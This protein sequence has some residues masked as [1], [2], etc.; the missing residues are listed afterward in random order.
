MTANATAQLVTRQSAMRRGP[1]PLD[2]LLFFVTIPVSVALMFSLVG[3]RLTNGMPW[4]DSFG[5]LIIHMA[6]TWGCVSLSCYAVRRVCRSWRPPV[7]AICII[8]YLAAV[9]PT[10]YVYQLTGDFFASIYPVF[11]LN[12]QDHAI[13]SWGLDYLLHFIRYAIPAL[14][15][16][17]VGTFGYRYLTGVNWFGYPPLEAKDA[18]PL[19][20]A[21]TPLASRIVND[22][23]PADAVIIAIKAEQHYIHIYSD[24]GTALVRYRF[25]DLDKALSGTNGS[26]VHRSWW[27][28]YDEVESS[29]PC[30]RTI[31]LLMKGDLKVPVSLSN[32]SAVL[33]QLNNSE[34]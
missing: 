14:P 18:A 9:M 31:E 24:Q 26:K 1:L 27:I 13:P 4:L 21:A 29:Q 19:P 25:K 6:I 20:P 2:Y 33:N 7:L 30:G 10:A 11:A 22:E 32:K 34:T 16:F 15:L 5:Y 23:L 28:N 3:T 12:R 8:G 17:L